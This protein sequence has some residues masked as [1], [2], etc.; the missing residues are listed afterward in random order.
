MTGPKPCE[1]VLESDSFPAA[2]LR[3]PCPK[4][5]EGGEAP[6]GAA[7]G[8]GEETAL[9]LAT[10]VMWALGSPGDQRRGRAPQHI[11]GGHQHPAPGDH[12]VAG[13]TVHVKPQG[14]ERRPW[15]VRPDQHTTGPSM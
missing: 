1:P 3:G 15:T 7:L 11:P 12:I 5:K 13:F 8:S 10:G 9:R 2:S 14:P 6:C 4:H